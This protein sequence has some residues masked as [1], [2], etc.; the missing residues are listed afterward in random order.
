VPDDKERA[1]VEARVG[2]LVGASH[3]ELGRDELFAGW[4]LFLERLAAAEPVVL[5]IEDLQWADTGLL[6]F[7]QYLLEWSRESR[8]FI[9]TL[10]R[11]EFTETRP[12]WLTGRREVF[13]L[14]LS[15]LADPLLDEM[16]RGLVP[17]LPGPLRQRIIERAQGVPLYAVELIRSLVDRDLV[18]PRDGVYTLL[19][20]V[21]QL[22]VPG[23]VTSLISAR[24]DALPSAE[25]SL[26]KDLA[27]LGDTFPASSVA[28]ISTVPV[29]RIEGLLR[30]LVAKE[31]VAVHKDPLS[32]E[33][34]R[35]V[36]VQTLLR[37]VAHGMLTKRERRSRHLAV[38]R[39]LQ[40]TYPNEGEE[41]AD[42]IAAHYTDAY[43][44]S[45][46][47]EQNELRSATV[48]ALARSGRRAG[49]IGA[50]DT[51][52]QAFRTAAELSVDEHEQAVLLAS[53]GDMAKQ[54]GRPTDAQNLFEK[55]A[56]LHGTAGRRRD[57]ARVTCRIGRCQS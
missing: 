39:H 31:I 2:V 21:D 22:E 50:P 10:A 35:Y 29:D 45:T 44:A 33:Q 18:V 46:I 14:H 3:A 15:P 55:A 41:V 51:A 34:G 23:T 52:E 19:G 24:L 1:F 20:N 56:R 27:V 28:A 32:P 57:A 25:R 16:L 7:L 54:G 11:P 13:T 42:V 5:L 26:I 4:R 40:A 9:L 47:D 38:A 53:A 36:F 8:I 17:N 12:D 49:L 30:T 48:H 37:D 43:H 6:D